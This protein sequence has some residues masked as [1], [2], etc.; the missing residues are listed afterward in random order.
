MQEVRILLR[1][2]QWKNWNHDY[3]VKRVIEARERE[4]TGCF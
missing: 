3:R 2:D 1:D 4:M